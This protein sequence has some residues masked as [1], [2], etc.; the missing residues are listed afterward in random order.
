V[1]C[2]FLE[3][4]SKAKKTKDGKKRIIVIQNDTDGV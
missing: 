1:I 3:H 2:L 4:L